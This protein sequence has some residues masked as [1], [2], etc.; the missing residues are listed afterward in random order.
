MSVISLKE[1]TESRETNTKLDDDNRVINDHKR[2]FMA[3]TDDVN[4]SIRSILDLST[5]PPSH[6]ILPGP[7]TVLPKLGDLHPDYT[8][9]SNNK[10]YCREID[11][12]T[13]EDEARLVIVFTCTYTTV[14]NDSEGGGEEEP[15]VK[16][17]TL[18][19]EVQ[20]SMK[21]YEYVCDK[22]YRYEEEEID[23]ET[24]PKDTH[25]KPSVTVE[26][27]A[28]HGFDPPKMLEENNLVINITKQYRKSSF[29]VSDIPNLKDTI[30]DSN[31]RI[32]GIKIPKYCGRM[33]KIE[34]ELKLYT[35][36]STG[37]TQLY[38]EV[39]IDIEVQDKGWQ[40]RPLDMGYK[41]IDSNAF[42]GASKNADLQYKFKDKTGKFRDKDGQKLPADELLF[43][44]YWATD[45]NELNIDSSLA[46]ENSF[47]TV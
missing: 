7:N 28:K 47:P 16:P 2:Y 21:S 13:K 36:P 39:R 37:D 3:I 29:D 11:A 40:L 24:I 25:Y 12:S 31:I 42:A 14:Y 26:N 46:L 20:Y 38:W 15:D 10:P 9:S 43:N 32:A 18:S 34:P 8:E 17:W 33:T 6:D 30:N 5:P 41:D 23:G 22:S 4:T 27:S 44:I 35:S 19:D 1:L 45:W